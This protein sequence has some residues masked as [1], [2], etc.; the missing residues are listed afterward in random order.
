MCECQK[1]GI[2]SVKMLLLTINSISN[3]LTTSEQTT[4]HAVYYLNNSLTN[5]S[6]LSIIV[7]VVVE[8]LSVENV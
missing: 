5:N 2:N 6:V 3:S 4:K 1:S 8:V 7:L